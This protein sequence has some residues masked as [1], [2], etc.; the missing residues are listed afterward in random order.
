MTDKLL[1]RTRSDEIVEVS[2]DGSEWRR[3]V[4]A[5]SKQAIAM[6]RVIQQWDALATEEAKRAG[7][8]VSWVLATIFAESGGNP[9]AK[10]QVGALGLMQIYSKSIRGSL[11]DG[12][13]LVPETNVRLGAS[14]LAKFR[15]AG[16]DLPVAASMYNAGGPCTRD[17]VVVSCNTK[18][19]VWGLKPWPSPKS[20][21]GY[22]EETGYI[23][24]IVS[25]N[26]YY[27]LRATPDG[28]PISIASLL[29]AQVPSSASSTAPEAPRPASP[30]T[31]AGPGAAQQAVPP[32]HGPAETAR[33]PSP[34]CVVPRAIFAILSVASTLAFILL[35]QRG[36]LRRAYSHARSVA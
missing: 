15:K 36:A 23:D 27:I 7:I 16:A 25:A 1:W 26:N 19:A 11:T 14:T 22:R 6:H 8:P 34:S 28:E 13:V 12:Q 31:A 33:A 29:P 9:R 21:W 20:H 5:T 24:H 10:S 32:S 35:K 17:G 4:L 18:G 3:P 30:P 2:V